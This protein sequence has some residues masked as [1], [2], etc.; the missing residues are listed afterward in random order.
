MCQKLFL[1]LLW[2]VLAEFHNPETK[3]VS[4]A[5]KPEACQGPQRVVAFVCLT[6]LHVGVSQNGGTPKTPQTGHF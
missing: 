6:W 1:P 5:P 2:K 4:L 3:A